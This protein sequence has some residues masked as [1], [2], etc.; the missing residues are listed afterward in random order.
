MYVRSTSAALNCWC[1]CA[2]I[3]T[4]GQAGAA[5]IECKIFVSVTRVETLPVY[6]V[7]QAK[8]F[9]TVRGL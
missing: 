5:K 6:E 7:R 4:V 1:I 9:T 2:S 8:Q 3:V